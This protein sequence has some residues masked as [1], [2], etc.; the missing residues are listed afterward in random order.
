MANFVLTDAYVSI[1]SVNLSA[2]V[3]S[4]TVNYSADTPD[5]TAMGATSMSRLGGLKDWSLEVEF[6][7]DFA[8]S[9]PDVSLFSLVGVSTA[10]EIRPTSGARSTTNPAFTGNGII[11]S[12][13]PISGKV[14]D[15]ASTKISMKG[16]GALSRATS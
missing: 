14:G 6:N 5:N 2:Y 4:V 10:V 3:N 9:A 15:K 13:P 12:Y 8:A 7:Q 16:N 11:D 1:N